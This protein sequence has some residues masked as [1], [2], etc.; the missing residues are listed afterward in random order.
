MHKLHA[1][2][3]G[4]CIMR[5]CTT[6]ADACR[7]FTKMD[8]TQGFQRFPLQQKPSQRCF[9]FKRRGRPPLISLPAVHAAELRDLSRGPDLNLRAYRFA[10]QP[11]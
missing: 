1:S 3:V 11:E 2:S 9:G 4:A 7:Q 8:G 5:F 10:F 6:A